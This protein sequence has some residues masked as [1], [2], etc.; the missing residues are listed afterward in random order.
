VWMKRRKFSSEEKARILMEYE[1]SGLTGKE[2]SRQSGIGIN[3]LIRWRKQGKASGSGIRFVEV[4]RQGSVEKKGPRYRLE[5]WS[6]M[7]LEFGERF[8]WQ[9]I[10]TLARILQ[11]L[12][13]CST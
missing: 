11:E 3:N 8:D 4:E 9:E 13:K 7:S 6:G 12:G 10:R 1:E 5:H 2:Y